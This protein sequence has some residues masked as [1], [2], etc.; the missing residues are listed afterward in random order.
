MYAEPDMAAA[1]RALQTALKG[2]VPSRE[3]ADAYMTALTIACAKNI[4]NREN[5]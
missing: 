4:L 1:D 3:T 2:G 5:G